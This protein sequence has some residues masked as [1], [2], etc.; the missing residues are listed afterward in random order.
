[1]ST[2]PLPFLLS[3]ALVDDSPRPDAARWL[4]AAR[5][6]EDA[7]LDFVTLDAGPADAVLV[8]AGV[9]ARTSRIGL[10]PVAPATTTEPFHVSTAI[11]TVDFAARG[12]AGW[13]AAVLPAAEAQGLVTWPVPADVHADAAEHIEAVRALWDS[14]ED[15]AV[16]RDAATA[17]FLDRSAVHHVHLRGEHIAVR[18]PSIT[19][20]PPQGHPPVAVRVAGPGDLQLAQKR[21]DLLFADGA[22]APPDAPGIVRIAELEAGP[23]LGARAAHADAAGFDGVLVH[24]RSDDEVAGAIT[25]L[26]PL[27]AARDG[28]LA[29]A[30]LRERLGLGPASNRFGAGRPS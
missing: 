29:P 20:R 23:E 1:M 5:A 12:R 19:P 8:A 21:A 17:R 10:L 26:G 11:A 7:G 2:R 27:A 3:V 6:A 25:A 28:Q 22:A 9:A 14:W 13:V 30:T 24:A 16:I 4:A 15:G 18:G